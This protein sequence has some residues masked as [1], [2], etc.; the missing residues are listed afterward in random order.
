MNIFFAK[1]FRK[2]YDRLQARTRQQCNEQLRLFESD[3]F[4]RS[5]E[6]HPLHGEYADCRSINV[7]GD[8]RAL[9]YHE[10]ENIVHFINIGTHHELFGT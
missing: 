4:H 10:G 8:Y 9:F 7:T 5:L 6:N 1:K 2:N 3:P